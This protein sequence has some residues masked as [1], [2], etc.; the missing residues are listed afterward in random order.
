[1]PLSVVSWTSLLFLEMD[2]KVQLKIKKIKASNTSVKRK[3][4][5]QVDNRRNGTTFFNFRL[6]NTDEG[7]CTNETC[8]VNKR[9]LYCFYETQIL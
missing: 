2:G 7:G 4:Q 9:K 5:I 3:K 6:C 1:M 8:L